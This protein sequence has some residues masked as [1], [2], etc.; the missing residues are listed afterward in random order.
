MTITIT[1]QDMEITSASVLREAV[2][3]SGSNDSLTV[4]VSCCEA[5]DSLLTDLI[6]DCDDMDYCEAP[7]RETEVWGEHAGSEIKIYIQVAG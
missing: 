6:R 2:K 3:A 7:D 1:P 4:L 5:H